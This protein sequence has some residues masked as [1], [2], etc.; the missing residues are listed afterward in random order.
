[1]EVRMI[2]GIE[3]RAKAEVLRPI[4][5]C[6]LTSFE[7]ACQAFPQTRESWFTEATLVSLLSTASWQAGLPSIIEAKAKKPGTFYPRLDLLMQGSD[8]YFAF[9]AK[10]HFVPFESDARRISDKLRQALDE[11]SRVSHYLARRYFGLAFVLIEQQDPNTYLNNVLAAAIEQVRNSHP[12]FD[13]LAWTL[14]DQPMAVYRGCVLAAQE[15]HRA[16]GTA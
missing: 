2:R 10:I 8:E 12:S 6:W 4:L 14:L 3:L 7:C 1:M 11:A 13:A 15:A 5:E 16:Q 9:E